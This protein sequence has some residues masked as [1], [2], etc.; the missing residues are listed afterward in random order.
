MK[1]PSMFLKQ[2]VSS[3]YPAAL[4]IDPCT[5]VSAAEREGSSVFS[6]FQGKLLL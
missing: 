1:A 4:S 3:S 6:T 5:V 2:D